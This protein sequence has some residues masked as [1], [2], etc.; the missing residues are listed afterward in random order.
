L[1]KKTL[2][3]IIIAERQKYL[4]ILA[5][6][7][8]IVLLAV[9]C[10]AS[11]TAQPQDECFASDTAQPQ[12][13]CWICGVKGVPFPDEDINRYVGQVVDWSMIAELDRLVDE[14]YPGHCTSLTFKP[15]EYEEFHVKDRCG[16]DTVMIHL[17]KVLLG[18]FLDHGIIGPGGEV[19]EPPVAEQAK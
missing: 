2:R 15:I 3:E 14:R 17:H 10:F 6:K 5:V 16:Q 4:T 18:A 7:V 8:L 19:L 12:D 1:E 13:E 11:D 9:P